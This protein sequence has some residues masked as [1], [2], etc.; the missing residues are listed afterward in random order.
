MTPPQDDRFPGQL[1]L[2]ICASREALAEAVAAA[3]REAIIGGLD[4][5]G[6]ASLVLPG[7]RTPQDYLPR[8]A[9]LDLPWSRV[10]IVPSDERLVPA[11]HPER[12]DRLLRELLTGPAGK[13]TLI[14][15]VDATSS[16]PDA[17]ATAATAALEAMP[18]PFDLVLLGVGEDS[19]VA[20]LFP[21]AEGVEQTLDPRHDAPVC[22]LRPPAGTQPA[23]PRLS[24]TLAA[25]LDSRRIVMAARGLA[26]RDA[27][28]RAALG[29][30]PQP[31]PVRAL[32]EHARQPVDCFWCR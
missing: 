10:R 31:S 9:A 19:H 16:D 4:E 17:A 11:G 27:F 24:L 14:P 7:G 15:L 23:W 8:V 13:A 28:E 6:V 20:S 21:G 2:H 12:N 18:R 22:V 26:K 5:R 30:W 32:A 25:L 3:V 1:A 29:H